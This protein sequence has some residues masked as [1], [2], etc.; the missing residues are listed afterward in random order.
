MSEAESD[1]LVK[2]MASLGRI[3]QRGLPVLISDQRSDSGRNNLRNPPLVAVN[4]AVTVFAVSIVISQS[5]VPEQAPL[6]LLK[7]EPASGSAVKV[8][9]E[10]AVK[11]AL[12]S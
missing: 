8:T 1:G 6:Q 2:L 7:V 5:L 11:A 10:S 4:V 12:Q 3:S 9:R